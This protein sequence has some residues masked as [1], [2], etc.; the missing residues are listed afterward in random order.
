MDVFVEAQP[1]ATYAWLFSIEH[2]GLAGAGVDE[3]SA[4]ADLEAGALT[5]YETFLERHGDRAPPITEASVVERLNGDELAF[6]R[7]KDAATS[8]HLSRTLKHLAWARQD[9]V[10]LLETAT[11]EELDW[12]DPSR[13]LP[14]WAWWR[15]ARQMAWHIAI[16]ESAYYLSR[17]GI[18]PPEP[19]S[20]LRSPLPAPSTAELLDLLSS[21][22]AHVRH[23]LQEIPLDLYREHDAEVWTTTKVLRRLAWHERSETD[24]VR[25]LLTD[26]K[27]SH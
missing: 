14:H 16:T 6:A 9:L 19:F 10:K 17:L 26:A 18:R 24:V 7:D 22:S 8:E 3:A 11:E 2:W 25:Q 13:S 4:L 15:S 12:D 23:A 5:A 27:A 21:S 1:D 20:S